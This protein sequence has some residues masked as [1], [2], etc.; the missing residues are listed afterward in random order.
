MRSD[1]LIQY[2][3]RCLYYLLF[4]EYEPDAAVHFYFALYRSLPYAEN[5]A[6]E[7]RRERRRYDLKIF[8]VV[9][10]A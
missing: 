1:R 6:V 4:H 3:D 5:V 10:H 8:H 7:A 2:A 9:V